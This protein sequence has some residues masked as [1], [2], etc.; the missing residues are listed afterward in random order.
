VL[1]TRMCG[2]RAKLCP[3]HNEEDTYTTIAPRLKSDRNLS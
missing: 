1:G 3:K 2:G